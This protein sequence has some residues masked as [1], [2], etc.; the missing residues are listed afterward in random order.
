MERKTKEELDKIKKKYNTDVLWSWSKY[1]CYKNSPYEYFL[2]YIAKIP[3]DNQPSI[4]LVQGGGVHEILEQFYENKIEY[5]DMIDKYENLLFELQMADM[6]YNRVDE[7]ANLKIGNKYEA[8]I[9]EFFNNHQVI[10]EKVYIEKFITINVKGHIFR[11]YIDILFKRD[12]NCYIGDWKTSTIYTGEKREKEM[13]QLKLYALGLHQLGVPIENIKVGWNFLKYKNVIYKQKN[14]NYKIQ[15]I[16][17]NENIFKKASIYKN[18]VSWLKH[19]KLDE[20][21][22]DMCELEN[23]FDCLPEEIRNLYK[24]EDCYDWEDMT[25]EKLKE[26]EEDV[27]ENIEKMINVN[28]E[29]EEKKDIKLWWDEVSS[30]SEYYYYN[31]CGYSRK[32]HLP[33][34]EYLEQQ[35]MFLNDLSQD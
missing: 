28:K 12:N 25:E 18:L 29:W 20:S 4:Y 17:R 35:E 32:L 3:E 14:G 1:N 6:K 34:N 27:Y 7:D 13:G 24:I 5:K 10:K 9:R 23:S 2:K 16:E 26:F 11:G 21:L 8:C 15:P 33:F 19:Y 22:A 31:L 30:K